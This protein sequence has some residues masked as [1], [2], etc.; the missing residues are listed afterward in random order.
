MSKKEASQK[1]ASRPGVGLDIGTMNIVA[2]RQNSDGS[3]V[4]RRIR[5]AFLDL[6][7]DAKR[8]LK[9]S[10]VN[11]IDKD[12]MLVVTSTHG[13]S[14]DEHDMVLEHGLD[15]FEPSIHVPLV[16]I[17][18][19]LP[20]ERVDD[21]VSTE[22]VAAL[23]LEGRLPSRHRSRAHSRTRL[24]PLGGKPGWDRPRYWRH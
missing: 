19:G 23:L 3:V 7:K 14:I 2:A 21:L 4:T 17:G 11:Y 13:M 9:M 6:D 1:G 12:D 18:G 24:Y 8:S 16:V 15:L 5:D 20:A 22:D 10:K